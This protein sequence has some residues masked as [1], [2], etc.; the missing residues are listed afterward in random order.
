MTDCYQ[1]VIA[2]KV[3]CPLKM[4]KALKANAVKASVFYSCP[5]TELNRYGRCGSPR[6]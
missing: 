5:G 3:N 2:E 6:L 4:K 1:T